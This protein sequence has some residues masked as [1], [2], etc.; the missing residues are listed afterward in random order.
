MMTPRNG[1]I[2][3]VPG[4]QMRG[5]R[6]DNSVDCPFKVLGK[7]FTH[8]SGLGKITREPTTSRVV[9]YPRAREPTTTCVTRARRGGY[10]LATPVVRLRRGGYALATPV[11]GSRAAG[12]ATTSDV[13]GS[14]AVFSAVAKHDSECQG[15]PDSKTGEQ[16]PS[17]FAFHGLKVSVRARANCVAGT[18]GANV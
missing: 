6:G 8:C 15:P 4:I 13:V 18:A 5:Q 10:A 11:S 7:G 3:N 1:G 12:E 16:P 2:P 9:D 17:D 14:R